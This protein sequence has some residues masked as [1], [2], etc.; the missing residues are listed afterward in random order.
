M[1]FGMNKKTTK[2]KSRQ[3]WLEAA[4]GVLSSGRGFESVR[5]EVLA[6]TMKVTKGSFYWHFSSRE[7]LLEAVVE[8]WRQQGTEA[9]I[10]ALNIGAQPAR[11]RMRSLW[12]MATEPGNLR[13]ELAIREQARSDAAL[14]EVVAQVDA[15]RMDTLRGIFG[16][17]G[18]SGQGLEA[19]CMLAYSLL[20]GDH[21]IGASHGPFKRS[22]VL[23]DALEVL[24]N[25]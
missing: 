20:I 16:E 21:F 17:L 4:I 22:D 11:E 15:R 10:D 6:R 9:I 19:R 12:S 7:A 23:L 3:D 5:V 25:S 14:R 2:R 8:A 1:V 13:V 24:L 18:H